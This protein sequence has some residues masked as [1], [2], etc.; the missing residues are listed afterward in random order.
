MT[1][2]VRP[3]RD[4]TMMALART[5]ARRSTCPRREVGA[6]LTDAH[7]R[8]LSLAHNGV[9][10]S[11]P[12]CSEGHPCGGEGY[13]SGLGLIACRAIHAEQNALLFCLDVMRIDSCYVTS[14]PCSLCVRTLLNTSCRRV[15]FHET[16]DVSALERWQ[17]TGRSW[18]RVDDLGKVL[19]HA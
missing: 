14:S 19:E 12:H 15:V 10:M 13:Q 2:L 9:A 6:V 18:E 5:I 1:T 7:G 3:S 11:E 17:A 4:A 16:Y 8:V